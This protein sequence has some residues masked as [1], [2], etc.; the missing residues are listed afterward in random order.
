MPLST[1]AVAVAGALL[2]TLA[3]HALEAPVPALKTSVHRG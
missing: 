1:N 3:T 2:G